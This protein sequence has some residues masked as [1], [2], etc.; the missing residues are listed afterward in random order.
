MQNRIVRTA[1]LL[2]CVVALASCQSAYYAA[3]EKLGWAKRDI[4]VDRVKAARNDQEQA[5]TEF[6]T[7]LQHLRAVAG[8]P[9]DSLQKEYDRIQSDYDS[10]ESRA[11][12][13]HQRIASV[14]Q[15]AHDLF[16][17]WEGE[18]AEYHSEE[19]RQAS[20]QKLHETEA[21][22]DQL[23]SAMKR[24]EAKMQPVLDA[25]HDQVLFMKHNLNARAIASLEQTKAGL[26]SDVAALI[27]DMNASI[28]EA[29]RFI[30]QMQKTE[31]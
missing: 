5:K 24:A 8:T 25:F 21:R 15:V 13:V 10:C 9:E 22:Y 1:L 17:E 29:D 26:E 14:D 12:K 20:S 19:L 7:T 16:K 30:D 27:R 11:K 2:M 4:L 23:L 18:L 6:Q 31:K 3:W 28:A